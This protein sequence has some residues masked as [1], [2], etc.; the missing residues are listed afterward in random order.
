MQ[1]DNNKKQLDQA[2]ENITQ[3]LGEK[4]KFDKELR[5]YL[6]TIKVQNIEET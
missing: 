3:M 2:F 5:E 6:E 1:I 4:I